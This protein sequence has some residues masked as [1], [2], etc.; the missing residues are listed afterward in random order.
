MAAVAVDVH[1]DVGNVGL[2]H[3]REILIPRGWREP[4]RR[5][6]RRR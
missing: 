3:G 1:L 5:S 4:G 2:E 6:R